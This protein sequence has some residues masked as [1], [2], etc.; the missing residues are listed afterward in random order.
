MN[1][2]F[3]A[4][5]LDKETGFYYYGARYLDPKYSRWISADPAMNTGEYFSNPDAGMGGIYNHV[6]F[7]LYHYANNN[8]I[9]YTDPD[10]RMSGA[11]PEAI[12]RYEQIQEQRKNAVA[13]KVDGQ[14]KYGKVSDDLIE[15]LKRIE[16]PKPDKDGKIGLHMPGDGTVT[17]GYGE[18]LE[19][20]KE[21]TDELKAQYP[22]MTEEEATRHL[23]EDVLPDYET[24]VSNKLYNRDMSA[25]QQEFDAY[26][27]SEFNTNS[28]P[29]MDKIKKSTDKSNSAI[30]K[31]FKE[32]KITYPGLTKRREAEAKVYTE[33]DYSEDFSW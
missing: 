12:K 5:E 8:P 14:K 29:L 6:N 24:W 19:G 3:S 7:N 2:M 32:H 27:L 28:G 17:Y 11:P 31:I 20:E 4:K 30:T 18:V 25:T 21:I 26:V 16:T 1:F 33:G 10:G 22:Q 9:R 13:G 15:L 23:I